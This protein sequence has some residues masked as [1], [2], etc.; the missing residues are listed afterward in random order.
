MIK[1]LLLCGLALAAVPYFSA[2]SQLAWDQVT[3]DVAGQPETVAGY[4]VAI[5]ARGGDPSLPLVA[6]PAPADAF[7]GFSLEAAAAGLADGPY[8]VFVR[9]RDAAGNTSTW[10]APLDVIL[11]QKAPAVPGN[12]RVRVTVEVGR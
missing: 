4:E 11:D 7:P 3:T 8:S 10:S 6:V 9:A 2:R 1:I 12:V 5:T